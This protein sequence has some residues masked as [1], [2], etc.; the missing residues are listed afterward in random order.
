[1]S[2]AAILPNEAQAWGWYKAHEA[3][4]TGPPEPVPDD[5]D[6]EWQVPTNREVTVKPLKS[7]VV[8]APP[9]PGGS[10]KAARLHPE[11]RPRITA[12]VLSAAEKRRD[13][14]AKEAE[15]ERRRQQQYR[16]F[17]QGE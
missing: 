17:D 8:S 14:E 10:D 9:S 13:R 5:P 12:R 6:G 4:A 2:P 16:L 11:D 15:A 3:A 7:M 1:M